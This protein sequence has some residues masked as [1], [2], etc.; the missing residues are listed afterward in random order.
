M[1]RAMD[2]HEELKLPAAAIAQIAQDTRNARTGQSG[3][4]RSTCTYPPCCMQGDPSVHVVT[5]RG[6]EGSS[7][8]RGVR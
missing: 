6:W 5:Y 8:G 1:T 3:V 4:R 7:R 2:F